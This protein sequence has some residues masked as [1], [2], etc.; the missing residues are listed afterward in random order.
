[1]FSKFVVEPESVVVGLPH[2]LLCQRFEAGKTVLAEPIELGKF[3]SQGTFEGNAL[4]PW[5]KVVLDC[6]ESAAHVERVEIATATE[7]DVDV[8][9]ALFAVADDR[10]RKSQGSEIDGNAIPRGSGL[11]VD[12]LYEGLVLEFR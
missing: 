3:G 11:V 9:I 7:R 5:A 2:H 8:V 4:V 6:I 1:M 10:E 12:E